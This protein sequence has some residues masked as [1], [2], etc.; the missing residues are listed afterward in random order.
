MDIPAINDSE[1]EQVTGG[2]GEFGCTPSVIYSRALAGIGTPA[3]SGIAC[4]TSFFVSYCICGQ[5]TR[6]G[7]TATFMS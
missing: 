7:T 1:L 3:G 2:A 4:D 5:P 6:I